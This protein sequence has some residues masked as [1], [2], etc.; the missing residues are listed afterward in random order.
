MSHTSSAA[1]KPLALTRSNSVYNIQPPLKKKPWSTLE[2]V[3]EEESESTQPMEDI[4]DTD[5]DIITSNATIEE[6]E[7]DVVSSLEKI[8]ES[9]KLILTHLLSLM[10]P[11]LN[12][13]MQK[14]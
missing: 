1:L 9:Q 8:K 7:A 11:G 12:S 5:D 14:S 6:W 2:T 3:T 4:V 10:K 13:D